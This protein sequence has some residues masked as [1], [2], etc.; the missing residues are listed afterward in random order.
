GRECGVARRDK[1]EGRID[2]I[3]DG[4]D[5]DVVNG[6][7]GVQARGR[8]GRRGERADQIGRREARAEGRAVQAAAELDVWRD[9][10]LGR[11]GRHGEEGRGDFCA[12]LGGVNDG[13]VL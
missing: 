4:D 3:G 5:V 10:W 8:V 1:G 2:E 11:R 6:V 7:E 13:E 9:L 12:V